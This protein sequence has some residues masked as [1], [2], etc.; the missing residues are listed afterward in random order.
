[1][2]NPD[3]E[4]IIQKV[5][6]S[7]KERFLEQDGNV[8]K[9][10]RLFMA[11]SIV[12]DVVEK[13]VAGDYTDTEAARILNVLEKYL[14]GE[15]ELIRDDGEIKVVLETNYDKERQDALDSLRDAYRKM[16]ESV[17]DND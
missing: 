10:D 9:A 1:M 6:E 7:L 13:K 3:T 16:L 12:R 5:F 4:F 11:R 2:D 17:T 14:K 15:I 8:L